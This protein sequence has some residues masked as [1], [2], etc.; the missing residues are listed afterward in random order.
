LKDAEGDAEEM[1][2]KKWSR[3]EGEVTNQVGDIKWIK[4]LS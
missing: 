2:R 1:R 3:N 4:W